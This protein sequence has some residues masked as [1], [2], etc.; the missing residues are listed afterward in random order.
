MKTPVFTGSAVALIT[1]FTDSGIDFNKIAELVE[2]QLENGTQAI[3]ACGTTAETAT[4]S[5]EEKKQV[6]R[7]I[8]EK[9]NGR[10]PVIAG[11]GSNC[12]QSALEMSLFAKQAGADALLVVTPYYN[13]TTQDGLV[14]HYTYI[15]DRVDLPL[16][17]YNVPS[18]TGLN[19]LPATNARLAAHPNIIGLKEANGNMASV[20]ETM[21]RAGKEYFVYSGSDE[22]TVPMLSL[23]AKGVIS[24]AANLCPA[25][26]VKLCKLW[27]DG[28]IAEAAA[29]Q[30]QMSALIA[31]LFSE[32]NPIPVK[33]AMNLL[34][35]N[36]GIPRLPLVEMTAANREKLA[37]SMKEFG[38]L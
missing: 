35:M 22:L 5:T 4:M 19:I 7:F 12:T 29:L 25:A 37:Q 34:G 2:W 3:V 30:V 21:H 28:K 36:V 18:R 11:T 15:A 24:V 38:L 10:V 14:A 8:I 23:G 20:A 27:F 26:M 33:A 1:P 13:K 17:T 32:V 9:T 6:I 16:I 31:N